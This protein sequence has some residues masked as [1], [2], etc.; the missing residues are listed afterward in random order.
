M[1]TQCTFTERVYLRSIVNVISRSGINHNAAVNLYDLLY[2]AHMLEKQNL[3][4]GCCLHMGT[5]MCVGVTVAGHTPLRLYQGRARFL[6]Q[7]RKG[8]GRSGILS[9]ISQWP[10]RRWTVP[11]WRQ[12]P[13]IWFLQHVRLNNKLYKLTGTLWLILDRKITITITILLYRHAHVSI[14]QRWATLMMASAT[15]F[16][17]PLQRATLHIS[18]YFNLFHN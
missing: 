2:E 7:P 13:L 8:P 15:M 4:G 9:E 3:S 1:N 12:H 14:Q 10:A 5:A 18:L 11:M 6:V 17:H 16:P